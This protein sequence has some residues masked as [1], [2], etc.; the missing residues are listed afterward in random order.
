VRGSIV[1]AI[2]MRAAVP[3]SADVVDARTDRA[4]PA[5]KAPPSAHADDVRYK[6]AMGPRSLAA[7]VRVGALQGFALRGEVVVWILS[8]TMPWVMAAL[9]SAAAREG[10][11]PG[12]D[13]PRIGAYFACAFVVRALTASWASWRINRDIR[14][15]SIAARMLRPVPVAASYAA[16]A[17]GAMPLRIA[18]S[19]VV[20]ALLVAIAGAGALTHDGALWALWALAIV[21]G[22][23]LSTLVSLA[24]GAL[25][26]WAES[27]VKL[28]DAWLAALF[29]FSGYTV[30]VALF[31][32]AVRRAID[33]LPFRYVIGVGVE[34][35][36]GAH[37]RDAAASLVAR[38]WCFVAIAALLATIAW[39]RGVRR[40]SAVGG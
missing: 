28:T 16:E 39:H 14:D 35:M 1:V 24:I 19:I 15:G 9:L 31:P 10:A 7:F 8:T 12:F 20:V 25:A 32:E 29:V 5:C 3:A 6:G 22:F 38:Q 23:L 11:V 18:T 2:M 21:G 4:V 34:L 36:I 37:D 17:I 26:F 13:P 40:F 33:C 27:T 30:P